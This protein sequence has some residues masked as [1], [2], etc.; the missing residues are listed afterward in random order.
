MKIII[1]LLKSMLFWAIVSALAAIIT[2]F[3]IIQDWIDTDIPIEVSIENVEIKLDKKVNIIYALPKNLEARLTTLP[4]PVIIKNRSK[5][6]L[7]YFYVRF[8][9]PSRPA[10][11]GDFL[12][13]RLVPLYERFPELRSNEETKK[14]LSTIVFSKNDSINIISNQEDGKRITFYGNK[15]Y[16][17]LL[18]IN[19]A[20][21]DII[22]FGEAFDAFPISIRLGSNGYEERTYNINIKAYYCDIDNFTNLI[23]YTLNNREQNIVIYPKIELEDKTGDNLRHVICSYE[24]EV[25]EL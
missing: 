13:R 15:Q 3:P 18:M 20:Y 10:K 14:L 8:E 2:I 22:E 7:E 6:S 12:I 25:R 23:K 19:V 16:E 24:C 21:D 4:F 17:N 11:S 5:K 1:N 9:S